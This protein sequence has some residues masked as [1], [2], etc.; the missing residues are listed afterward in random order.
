MPDKNKYDA[1]IEPYIKEA[2]KNLAI[3]QYC[4][5]NPDCKDIVEYFRCLLAYNCVFFNCYI[6]PDALRSALLKSCTQDLMSVIKDFKE[7]E[8]LDH[9]NV[10][11]EYD[12]TIKL[13]QKANEAYYKQLSFK[14]KVAAYIYALCKFYKIF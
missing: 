2:E 1:C 4:V 3:I 7:K 5:T 14:F 13:F 8:K 9:L 6:N 12:K 11:Q 10:Q